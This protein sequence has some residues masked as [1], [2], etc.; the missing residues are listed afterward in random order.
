ME[1]DIIENWNIKDDC[2]YNLFPVKRMN[3]IVG[4]P[5]QM[6]I[7]RNEEILKIDTEAYNLPIFSRAFDQDLNKK[8]MERK[9]I[10]TLINRLTD[11][12]LGKLFRINLPQVLLYDD[13]GYKEPVVALHLAK[14]R[15]NEWFIN[16]LVVKKSPTTLMRN[17]IASIIINNVIQLARNNEIEYLSGYAMNRKVFEILKNKS[18]IA[19]DRKSLGHDWLLEM[20]NYTGCQFPVFMKL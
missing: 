17:N 15:E 19:D 14:I 11:P 8:G 13:L 12:D 4:K 5:F 18:F 20:A 3:E 2:F 7:A 9:N 6:C 10:H 16:D 1:Y